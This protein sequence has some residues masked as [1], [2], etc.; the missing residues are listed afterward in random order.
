[1]ENQH[2]SHRLEIMCVR[3]QT[4]LCLNNSRDDC[5]YKEHP[6]RMGEQEKTGCSSS[7]CFENEAREVNSAI[8]ELRTRATGHVSRCLGCIHQSTAW[9]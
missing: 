2:Y 5:L 6:P 4:V 8:A 1:M 7:M 9:R 3:V